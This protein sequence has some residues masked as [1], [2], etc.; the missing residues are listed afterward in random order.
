MA[1]T[2]AR[3]QSGTGSVKSQPEAVSKPLT[4]LAKIVG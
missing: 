4:V 1:K 2:T 3:E